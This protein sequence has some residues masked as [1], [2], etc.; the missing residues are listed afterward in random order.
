VKYA[1]LSYGHLLLTVE[2]VAGVGVAVVRA[3]SVKLEDKR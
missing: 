3:T 1:A 2:P